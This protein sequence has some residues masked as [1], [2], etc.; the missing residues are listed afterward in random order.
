MS[1]PE[2]VAAR[3]AATEQPAAAEQI[4]A[5]FKPRAADVDADRASI[6]ESLAVLGQ[7]GLASLDLEAAIELI[8]E[9]ARFDLASAFSAWAHRMVTHYVQLAPLGS[10]VRGL[11]P[12]L[13]TGRLIGATALA[14]GTAR[15]LSGT[16][17]PVR[18]RREADEIVID[19]R[20]PWASNLLAPFLVVTAAADE[21]DD[22][23]AIVVAFTDRTPG[24][25][26]D[27]PPDLLALQA[28]GS[29]SLTLGQVRLPVEW[30][31]ADD[32]T[33]F[34]ERI[35]PS[36]LLLQSAFCRGL[37]SRALVEAERNFGQ[38]SEIIRPDLEH[39]LHAVDDAEHDL[40]ELA[41]RVTDATRATR[42]RTAGD[43]LIPIAELLRIRLR[44][45]HLARDAVRL[46]LLTAGGRGYL[47]GSGTARRVREAAFL[48]IQAPT[49][50]QLQWSLSRFA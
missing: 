42:S 43:G 9:V 10:P 30:I 24:V 44:W 20:V 6:R 18:F 48:P 15:Y 39:V 2:A 34:A 40:R 16:P 25:T 1:A 11:L 4:R 28:T 47:R 38:A 32:L 35:L 31:V 14:A 27:P 29:S 45:A 26:V 17:L 21:S 49:E 5:F 41:G 19:G 22:G 8:G 12:D 37:A 7:H 36:F 23:R 13:A 50:V 33:S 3:P 46:E